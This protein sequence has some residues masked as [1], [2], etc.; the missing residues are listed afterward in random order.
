MGF[1][2]H[3]LEK[4]CASHPPCTHWTP[5]EMSFYLL[6]FFLSLSPLPV[7]FLV[8][9]SLLW[10]QSFCWKFKRNWLL[11]WTMVAVLP[12]KLT[13]FFPAHQTWSDL[14]LSL[15][16]SQKHLCSKE[17]KGLSKAFQ[18]RVNQRFSNWNCGNYK[19]IT[20]HWDWGAV[21]IK[22]LS[23]S[24]FWYMERY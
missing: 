19:H 13:I 4:P 5:S 22:Y 20:S 1:V 24:G 14:T 6:S 2:R 23:P 12:E 16:L 18:G 11:Y 21:F 7:R 17:T 3:R 9:T 10:C 15:S 8:W